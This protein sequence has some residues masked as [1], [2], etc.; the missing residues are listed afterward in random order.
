VSE[1]FSELYILGPNH[2]L[3]NIPFNI[4]AGVIYT[5]YLGVAN[6]VGS[7]GYYIL[8]VNLRNETA[9]LSNSTFR[10]PNT[11]A[12]YE[13]AFFIQ[14]G[15]NWGAPLVFE[16][17][18]STF[19]N[20]VSYLSTITINGLDFEVNESSVWNSAKNVYYYGLIMELWLFNSTLGVS[21]NNN[22][23]VRLLLNM[24]K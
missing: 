3:D 6:H 10:T 22:R 8:F 20:G 18:N 14:N 9:P 2:T 4:K 24:T 16:F 11:S 13:Y 7:S 12:L 21:E 23:S 17:K 5:I 15:R 1:E 19:T